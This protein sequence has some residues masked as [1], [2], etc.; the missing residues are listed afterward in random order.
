MKKT[1]LFLNVPK[2]RVTNLN[3]FPSQKSMQVLSNGSALAHI[4]NTFHHRGSYSAKRTLISTPV[5]DWV[6]YPGMQPRSRK[7]I[8][9]TLAALAAL[10]GMM[11][12]ANE[13]D[14]EEESMLD[15]TFFI[16]DYCTGMETE[17]VL[18]GPLSI[19][20]ITTLLELFS[21]KES[22]RK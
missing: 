11:E 1:C 8:A 14:F 18:K 21:Q 5:V 9:L 16:V 20:A 7:R 2:N 22:A 12:F 13:V 10:F 19:F 3:G 6:R 15:F 4:F 17:K